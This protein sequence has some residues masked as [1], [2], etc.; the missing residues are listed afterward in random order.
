MSLSFFFTGEG[1]VVQ[2]GERNFR[3]VGMDQGLEVCY[4]KPVKG[5]GG[6][7]GITRREGALAFHYVIK[8]D[9]HSLNMP[10]KRICGII[11]NDV[12]DLHHTI[13]DTD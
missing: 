11:E 7:I 2:H 13:S 12:Y 3:S 4:N 10:H 1:F 5:K 6:L 8:Y 9:T